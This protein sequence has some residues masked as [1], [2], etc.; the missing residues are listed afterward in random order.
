MYEWFYYEPPADDMIAPILFSYARDN[1]RETLQNKVNPNDIYP[2]KTV[3]Q[4]LNHHGVKSFVFENKEIINTNYSKT[5][6]KGAEIKGYGTLSNG[7]KTLAEC[8]ND[9]NGKAY[10]LFYYD[11]IDNASHEYGPGSKKSNK[12]VKKLLKALEKLQLMLLDKL[13][14]NI[15]S[16]LTS[17]HGQI[18]LDPKKMS[19]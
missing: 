4:K 6:L 5:L 9:E 13:D 15:L 10:Y 7:L 14:E 17:D 18:A 2:T 16:I 3:Y 8:I 19:I 11:P 12:E 1:D